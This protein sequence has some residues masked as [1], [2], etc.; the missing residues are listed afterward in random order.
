MVL[1]NSGVDDH[2]NRNKIVPT[3]TRVVARLSASGDAGTRFY[4]WPQ[5]TASSRLSHILSGCK[6]FNG[7]MFMGDDGLGEVSRTL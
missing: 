7:V 3:K 2:G 5:Q 1:S 4:D 6:L